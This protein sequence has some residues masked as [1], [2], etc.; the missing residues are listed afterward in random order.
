M[1]NTDKTNPNSN[2]IRIVLSTNNS[3][4]SLSDMTAKV[5]TYNCDYINNFRYNVNKVLPEKTMK[6]LNMSTKIKTIMNKKDLEIFHKEL[7]N[8]N[9]E[10]LT[11]K[12]NSLLNKLTKNNIKGI[13]QQ[14][15]EIL[16]SRKVLIEFA[17]KKIMMDAIQMPSLVDTY[18]QFYQK[19]YTPKTEEIFQNTFKEL[20]DALNGKIDSKINSAKDYDKFCKYLQD[21]TKYTGLHIFLASLYELKIIK[22]KQLTDQL[23]ILEKTILKSTP[24]ENEKYAECYC[25]LLKKLNKKSFI[26]M[27]KVSDIKESGK[28]KIRMRF[29]I[30]DIQD[31][32][33]SL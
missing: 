25:K 16:K 31:L 29:A 7:D 13:F 28:L 10:E 17:I 8:F 19:L 32:Y 20:M 6:I 15:S 5:I 21:K 30:M 2:P 9:P 11:K 27:K 33:K 24:E 1:L 18:A 4:N 23:K 26:N 22:K 14:V 3:S 12:I